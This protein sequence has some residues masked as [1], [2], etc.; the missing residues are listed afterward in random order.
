MALT[1]LCISWRTVGAK[2]MLNYAIPMKLKT[3]LQ[4]QVC[5]SLVPTGVVP[6][7]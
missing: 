4:A 6:Q 3:V 1:E 2:V 7:P 5:S